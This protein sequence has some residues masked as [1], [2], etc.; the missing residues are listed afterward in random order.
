MEIYEKLANRYRPKTLDELIGQP[1][2][3]RQVRGMVTSGRIA[4]SYLLTGPWG[5]GKT[6][7]ARLLARY[8]NCLSPKEN[9]DPC[10][11]CE[12]C[13]YFDDDGRGHPD[14]IEINMGDATGIDAVRE[15]AG[16]AMYSPQTNYRIYILDEVHA[17]TRQAQSCLLKPLEETPPRTIFVLCTT[18]PEKLNDTIRSRCVKLNIKQVTIKECTQLLKNVAAAEKQDE[19]AKNTKALERI[20]QLTQAHPRDALNALESVVNYTMNENIS[21]AEIEDIEGFIGAIVEE[22]LDIPIFDMIVNYMVAIYTGRFATAFKILKH[23]DKDP[24]YFVAQCIEYHKQVLFRSTKTNGR[25]SLCDPFFYSFLDMLDEMNLNIRK[26]TAAHILQEL[27]ATASEIRSYLIDGHTVLYSSTAKL[28]EYNHEATM[29]G[30]ITFD[31][32]Y[33][34][35]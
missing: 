17:I 20:A 21:F 15:I 32:N 26:T 9:G 10:N 31:S 16:S 7:A 24:Y 12:S 4:R 19:L 28:L 35:H 18:N 6:S 2:I 27:V 29:S 8:L 30:H 25:S 33:F 23:Y 13:K 22:T 5:S 14:V 11:E 34:K 3:T 1:N